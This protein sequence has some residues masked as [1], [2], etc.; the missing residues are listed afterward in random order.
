MPPLQFLRSP[1]RLPVPVAPMFLVS[2]PD[3]VTA[4]CAAGIVGTF[5][6]LNARPQEALDDWLTRIEAGLAAYRRAH[7]GAVVAPYGVNL[8]VHPTNARWQGDLDAGRAAWRQPAGLSAQS[9]P[10]LP[11]SGDRR[12]SAAAGTGHLREIPSGTVT[13]AA[14]A[15]RMRRKD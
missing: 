2:G 14:A 5:P 13:A 9:D 1:T 15:A 4:Q 7:P 12:S 8:I 6:S 11:Q 10:A 3:L